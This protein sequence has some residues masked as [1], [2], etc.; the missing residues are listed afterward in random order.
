M[1]NENS[2]PAFIRLVLTD[3]QRTQV[4]T[5]VG[6]DADAIELTAHELE[7]RIAPLNFTKVEFKNI[8]MNG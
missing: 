5:S 7:E 6:V 8:P 4:R 1:Q 3:D 2:K